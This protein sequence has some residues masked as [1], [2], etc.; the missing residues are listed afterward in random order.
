ML[1]CLSWTSSFQITNKGSTLLPADHWILRWN[2]HFYCSYLW[3]SLG[4]YHIIGLKLDDKVYCPLP[5]YHGAGGIL[6]A[7]QAIISGI[8]VVI[9]RKFSAS[10][11]IPDCVRHNCTVRPMKIVTLNC[12]S[13]CLLLFLVV[14]LLQYSTVGSDTSAL[15]VRQLC[16]VNCANFSTG[17]KDT[18]LR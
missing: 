7:G 13:F 3:I 4:V 6:C 5:L 15:C 9:K 18:F 14:F 2:F 12:G 16:T 8:T 10:Q 17:T 11:F 1:K